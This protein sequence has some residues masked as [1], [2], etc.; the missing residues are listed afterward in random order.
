MD[1][2]F[3]GNVQSD[4]VDVKETWDN[5]GYYN[6]GRPHSHHIDRAHSTANGT[7][8]IS[9]ECTLALGATYTNRT[10]NNLVKSAGV[11]PDEVIS[12]Q[13]YQLEQ[14]EMMLAFNTDLDVQTAPVSMFLAQESLPGSLSDYDASEN[15]TT[16]TFH[17]RLSQDGQIEDN[18]IFGGQT[19]QRPRP[20][21]SNYFAAERN[22]EVD[23]GCQNS[24]RSNASSGVS[25]SSFETWPQTPE[26][27]NPFSNS[28]SFWL[29]PSSQI[30][31]VNQVSYTSDNNVMAEEGPSTFLTTPPYVLPSHTIDHQELSKGL[32]PLIDSPFDYT[33]PTSE[34]MSI[35]AS[36]PLGN[37]E[38]Q[39][40]DEF[41]IQCR[42]KSMSY[43]EIKEKGGFEQ[44]I[45]TLRGRYRNLTKDKRDRLRKPKWTA[46]DVSEI[47]ICGDQIDADIVGD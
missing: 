10:C 30:S 40:R 5:N 43:K 39:T 42:Q 20:V 8:S 37:D 25:A 35:N 41:L 7:E 9:T 19:V 32:P 21:P 15:P 14:E 2:R 22:Q 23:F 34:M 38:R 1:V 16:Y 36:S 17:S 29:V 44:S 46:I 13:Q 24:L 18:H 6:R 31:Q 27:S 33:S 45:S 47:D 12:L 26:S 11:S 28:I 3:H 4:S